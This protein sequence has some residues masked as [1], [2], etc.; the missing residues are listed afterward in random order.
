M[1]KIKEFEACDRFMKN[2][3]PFILPV[4]QRFA[5]VDYTMSDDAFVVVVNYD[6]I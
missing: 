4:E 5:L 3:V 6:T 1:S 2:I